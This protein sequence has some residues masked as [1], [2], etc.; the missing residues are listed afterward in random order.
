MERIAAVALIVI[1]FDGGM[2]I[3]WR[4]FRVAAVPILSLGVLGTFATGGIAGVAHYVLGLDWTTSGLLGA[5]LAPTDPAVM[6]SVLGD[7]EIGGGPGRSSRASP[8]RTTR[9]G[10]R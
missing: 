4:R 6:F 10:S 7:R 9:S 8:A 3:G 2:S 5:A 1:L